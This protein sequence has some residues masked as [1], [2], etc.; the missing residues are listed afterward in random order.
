MKVL[1][2]AN[3]VAGVVFWRMKQ[4]SDTMKKKGEDTF[5]YGYNPKE[6]SQIAEWERAFEK[7][8]R[9]RDAIYTLLQKADITVM[10]YGHMHFIPPLVNMF[11][12]EF[13]KR[14]LCEIDDEI[15]D[16]PSYN[17]AFKG[18]WTPGNEYE[19]NVID[20]MRYSNGVITS[21]DF[22]RDYYKQFNKAIFTMPN[23]IDFE[24]WKPIKKKSKK[25]R[26][27]WIGGGNHEEDLRDL[28]DVIPEVLKRCKNVEFYFVHGVPSYLKGIKGVKHNLTW[29]SIDE[30]PAHVASMGFDIGLAPLAFNKFNM[31]KSNLRWLE[32]SSLGIPTVATDIEPYAKSIEQG[33]TGYVCTTKEDW[34]SSICELVDDEKKRDMV[35]E[36]AM[37]EVFEK[38]NLDTVADKYIKTLRSFK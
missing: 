22:L 18:G 38:F 28:V 8:V 29:V 1:F 19:K 4:F 26:V 10:Q 27:G 35:G 12:S 37:Q 30:Y 36:G 13:K 15:I 14:I 16:T 21:T 31:A 25:V 33:K 2:L 5:L 3:N 34:I 24:K 9:Y 7:D 20:H 32:Y 17:P 6:S 23:C 11:Q